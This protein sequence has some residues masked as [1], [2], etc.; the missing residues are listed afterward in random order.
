MVVGLLPTMIEVIDVRFLP[1]N[2]CHGR[3]RLDPPVELCLNIS[4]RRN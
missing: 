1:G 4:G 3:V 2:T